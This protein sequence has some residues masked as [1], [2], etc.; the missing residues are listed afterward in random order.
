MRT[1][2]DP[3]RERDSSPM[4]WAVVVFAS[5]ATVALVVL[6]VLLIVGSI[7]QQVETNVDRKLENLTLPQIPPKYDVATQTK[8]DSIDAWRT[9]SHRHVDSYYDDQ[10][11]GL[12]DSL[13]NSQ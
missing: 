11:Q 9:E 4:F 2:P 8:L 6:V 1:I 7:K 12:L 10:L 13:Y 5:L 3:Q